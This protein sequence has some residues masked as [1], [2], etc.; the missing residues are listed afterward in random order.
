M[1]TGALLTI[2]SLALV[3]CNSAGMDSTIAQPEYDLTATAPEGLN[4][5]EAQQ[6]TAKQLVQLIAIDT[7]NPPGNELKLA[8]YLEAVLSA[9]PGIETQVL[10]VSPGR[11]DFVAR[12]HAMRPGKKAV[13]LMAHSDVVG[14][15]GAKWQS[16]PFEATTRDAYLYGRGVIDDKG[17][18]AAG[19]TAILSL[20]KQREVLDRDVILLATAGEE[21]GGEGIEWLT[22]HAFPY[23]E[24]AEFAINEGGRVRLAN[25]R[26]VLVNI[27]TTEKVPYNVL[28]RASG[29]SGHGSI[30]LPN[31]AL[32]ALAR[33]V[34]KVHEWRPPVRLN[35]TTRSYFSGLA[36]IEQDGALKRAMEQLSSSQDWITIDKSAEIVSQEPRYNAM[37]RTGVS[38]TLIQGGIRSNVIPSEATATFNVRLIPGENIQEV[39]REMS[40]VA[41][42]SQVTFSVSGESRPSPPASSESTALYLALK[43]AAANMSPGVVVTSSMSSGGTDGAVLRAKGIPTYG[44][45]PLPLTVDDE[46]RMHGDNERVPL[47]SLGWAAEYLYRALL[48]VAR[49]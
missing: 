11:A 33:A 15:D 26:L 35:E 18:L 43:E 13:L 46:L 12:L 1:R 7:Q 10:E 2:I 45:L 29:P 47:A 36:R 34:A 23:I 31:N 39:V 17:M 22:K 14:V 3:R 30:P 24:D 41:G 21:S 5:A 37:L 27:Q 25:G 42:E 40:R 49:R 16:P 32:A 20:A 38:V 8:H 19:L 44:I 6:E 48:L 4:R 28:A 9:V